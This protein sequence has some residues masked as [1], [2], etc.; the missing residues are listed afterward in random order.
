MSR[1]PASAVPPAGPLT[2]VQCWDIHRAGKDFYDRGDIR[3]GAHNTRMEI[4]AA[5][6]AVPPA[7]PDDDTTVEFLTEIID[8]FQRLQ[9]RAKVRGGHGGDVSAVG[10]ADEAISL[11]RDALVDAAKRRE[12]ATTPTRNTPP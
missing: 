6:A 2:D 7:G 10:I 11:C 4:R 5:L 1:D 9:H 3:N 12:H 8:Y